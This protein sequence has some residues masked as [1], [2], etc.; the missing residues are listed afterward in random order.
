M[1]LTNFKDKDVND[2]IEQLKPTKLNQGLTSKTIY[3][4]TFKNLPTLIGLYIQG[5]ETGQITEDI[6]YV[7]ETKSKLNLFITR[8]KNG[9]ANKN[10]NNGY[11][12]VRDINNDLLFNDYV[13]Q[14]RY[15]MNLNLNSNVFSTN[16]NSKITFREWDCTRAKF[17]KFYQEAKSECEADWVCD[18]ACSVNPCFISYLAYAVGK[19]SGLI[20]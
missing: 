12:S 16:S 15:V 5:E 14:N 6:F 10:N 3:K 8:E 7:F 20:E 11:I 1:E 17:N 2:L 13:D 19:C 4:V 9:F 18:V